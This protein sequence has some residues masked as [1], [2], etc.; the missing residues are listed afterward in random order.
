MPENLQEPG[1][2]DI[3]R[4]AWGGAAIALAI[5]LAALA[6]YFLWRAE[7]S[8]GPGVA[9]PPA[10]AAPSLESA[11]Q[12]QRARYFAEKQRLLESYA[13]VDRRAGIA[14]IPLEQ[15]MRIMAARKEGND[16]GP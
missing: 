10:M 1:H 14:R 5:A 7:P 8:G 15:A 3:R 2:I 16:G 6:S 11:P 9:A 12:D 4:V 13:W